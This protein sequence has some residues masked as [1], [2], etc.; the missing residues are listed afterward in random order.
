MTGY[1]LQ[2]FLHALTIVVGI[3]LLIFIFVELAPGDAVDS[4]LP[5][6]SFA[7]AETKERMRERL[8]LNDPAPLRYVRW[9][10]R[11]ATGDM[12]Y[13]LASQKP[14]TDVIG[15][16]LPSTLLLVGFALLVW[17][18]T[19]AFC[20]EK[21]VEI[22]E[23]KLRREKEAIEQREKEKLDNRLNEINA[24]L[25]NAN[26]KIIEAQENTNRATNRD[27][28]NVNN[29]ELANELENRLRRK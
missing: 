21:R 8:G 11:T 18:L 6:E 19:W 1:L 17:I 5:P 25:I 9:L 13:S 24:P 29:Q 15:A 14:I 16:R 22:D 28:S 10:G 7:S 4:M 12:G 27:Y 20:G 23:E 3:S 2:R 26:Q